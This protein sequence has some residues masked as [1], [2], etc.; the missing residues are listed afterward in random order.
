[1][2]S[3]MD[4]YFAYFFKDEAFGPAVS[5]EAV[6]PDEIA[7]FRSKLPEQLLT[8]WRQHGW[9]GY[10]KGLFWFVNPD[11]YESVLEAWIG[12]T[13][14]METDEYYVVARSAFGE[15]FLWGRR[16]G[17]GLSVKPLWGMIFPRDCTDAVSAGKADAL[18]QSFLVGLDK[19]SL[20]QKDEFDK[21][22][23][24]RAMKTLGPLAPDEM[25]AFEPA[26]AVGGAANLKNLRKVKCVEHLVMLAQLGER[27]IMRDIVKD[28]K[29]A[30]IL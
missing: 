12:D 29:A 2:T 27:Q 30:G 4:K 9:A 10:G 7:R 3:E 14:L 8:Y 1:M 17:L 6:A 24:D 18:V 15:L 20:D 11:D 28:G 22:L 19:A 5:V 26:L 13:P 25:Y 21:P 23:F 16:T